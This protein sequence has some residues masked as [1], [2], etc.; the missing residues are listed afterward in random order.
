MILTGNCALESMGLKTFGFGGRTRRPL[1]AR[2]RRHLLG[3]REAEWLGDNRYSGERQL[4]TPARRRADGP[5]LCQPRGP[6]RQPRPRRSAIDIRET[7]ARMAMNDEETVALIAG[8]PHLRQGPLRRPG[9]RVC[10]RRARG[11]PHRAAWAWAGRTASGTG[12]AGST[13]TSDLEGAWT[14]TPITWDN[15]Y[16]DTL[17]KYEWRLTKSPGGA[18]AVGAR[19][20]R[21]LHDRSRRARPRHEARADDAHHRHRAPRRSRLREDLPPVP[22]EPRP[23]RRRLR[24]RVVQA[25][26]PRH[27]PARAAPRPEVPEAHLAGPRPRVDHALVDDADI[28]SLKKDHPRQRPVDLPPRRGRVGRRRRPSGAPTSG[29][30]PTADA[31]ASPRRRTGPSTTPTP[32]PRPSPPSRRSRASSTLPRAAASASRSPTPSSSRAAPPSRRPR[33]APASTVTVPFRPGRTDAT[34]ERRTPSPSRSSSPPPT[35]SATTSRPTTSAPP[36]TSSST[37]PTCSPSRPPR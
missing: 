19:R 20:G 25:H 13:I 18:T 5:D 30:A 10:R 11:R 15:T 3:P 1:R 32:S 29:A 17:F 34:Q 31:S 23:V 8:R 2:R 7:F 9:A 35:A 14:P 33:D 28:A 27:G 4:E 24:P 12:N 37:A 6:Q 26:P 22:R 16:F 21:G 36:S